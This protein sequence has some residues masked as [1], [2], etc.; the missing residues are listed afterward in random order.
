MTGSAI[1]STKGMVGLM[2]IVGRAYFALRPVAKKRGRGE[3]VVA[4]YVAGTGFAEAD[5]AAGGCWT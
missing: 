2:Q 5:F 4:T 3:R 1:E